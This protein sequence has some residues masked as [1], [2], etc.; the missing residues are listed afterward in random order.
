MATT[1]LDLADPYLR[2]CESEVVGAAGGWWLLSRTVFY[3]GGGGQPPDHGR[4]I[5][6]HSEFA[7]SDVRLD[8]GDV[9]HFVGDDRPAGGRVICELDWGRR[10]ALMRH[11][12]LMHIVN[13]VAHR[14]QGGLITGV[15]LGPQRSRVDFR[16]EA[17][18]RSHLEGFETEVNRVIG[19]DLA[20]SARTITAAEFRRRPDLIRTLAAPPP[21]GR[22][23]VRIVEIAGF[24]AQ[25][26]G[27]T[28]VHSTA[29]IGGPA[30]LVD[31]QN[32]GRDNKRLYWEL[33]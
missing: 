18:E 20:I 9:W 11:H 22:E 33:G 1:R 8:G 6:P 27:G 28:H 4:L 16:F 10:L 13:T 15:Q 29:D 17:F 25:A 32:R 19:L 21:I 3:P 30:R 5:A 26:C 24:D 23:G 12:A 14:R 7:V 2:R 31:F